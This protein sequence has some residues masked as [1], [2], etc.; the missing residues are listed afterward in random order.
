M[1]NSSGGVG[2]ADSVNSFGDRQTYSEG[3]HRPARNHDM[4]QRTTPIPDLH[5]ENKGHN[6]SSDTANFFQNSQQDLEPQPNIDL[7]F[8]N[9]SAIGTTSNPIRLTAGVE[10][11]NDSEES[12]RTYNESLYSGYTTSNRD[13]MNSHT[14]STRTQEPFTP[15]PHPPPLP[16]STTNLRAMLWPGEEPRISQGANSNV[17]VAAGALDDRSDSNPPEATFEEQVEDILDGVLHLI[18]DEYKK[19]KDAKIALKAQQKAF[20][21]LY[22]SE[23]EQLEQ[24]KELWLQNQRKAELLHSDAKD[25]IRLNVGGTH[26]ITTT[27]A[28]ISRAEGSSLAAMFN[29]RHKLQ[30]HKGRVFIDRDGTSFTLLLTYLRNGRLPSFTSKIQENAFYEELDYWQ[31]PLVL[32]KPGQEEA[33]EFDPGWCATTLRIENNN[34]LVRKHGKLPR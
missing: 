27:K 23:K 5:E 26:K 34:M 16:L 2:E 20:A 33:D 21:D 8:D 14:R 1:K 31:T 7:S 6:S 4:T 24:A 15:L 32:L 25:I 19:L 10:N 9:D 28:T 13:D 12:L 18:H 3:G 22:A 11:P 29:G 30:M 17:R